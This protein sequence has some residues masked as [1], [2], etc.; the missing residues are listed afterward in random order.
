MA[1]QDDD[2]QN[3][4]RS[5]G[6]GP[7]QARGSYGA[8][9]GDRGRQV[10]GDRDQHHGSSDSERGFLDR[11]GDEVRSWFGDEDA[12]RRRDHDGRDGGTSDYNNENYGRG[13]RP[14]GAIGS[15]TARNDHD[16]HYR[17]WRQQQ[18][19]A[20]D[21]DYHEYRQH[22]QSKFENDFGSWRNERQGQRSLLNQVEKHHEVVGS[23]GEHVGTVDKVTGDRIV[24]TKNDPDAGG[25]H[26]SIPSIWLRSADGERITIS[27]TAAE[28]KQAW[29][30]EDR[31]T[32]Y[33]GTRNNPSHQS[34]G[35]HVLNKSF[36]GTY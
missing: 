10:S 2:Y 6:R 19:D 14:G 24:L 33:N 7:D 29:R 17:A 23:D 32:M 5:D 3:R 15:G 8:N 1:Y 31:N 30:D 9:R 18:I 12:E 4:G 35:P 34:D 26:H 22:S 20:L 27:K 28:A 25:H 21:R 13:A 36:S 16:P 11:A